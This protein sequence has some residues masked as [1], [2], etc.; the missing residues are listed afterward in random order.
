M[1]DEIN[2]NENELIA[3]EEAA[4]EA[5]AEDSKGTAVEA[6]KTGKPTKKPAKKAS[7]FA[8]AAKW[9]RDLRAEA[10]KVIWPTRK[11]VVNNTV[12]VILMVVVVAAFVAGLDIA[13]GFVHNFL[14][15]IVG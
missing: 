13:F 11:Q 1:A 5:H 14:A 7:F 2:K 6:K 9:F 4:L 12:I 3:E 10:K 15:T 8:R